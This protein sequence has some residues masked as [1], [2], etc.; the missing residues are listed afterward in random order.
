MTNGAAETVTLLGSGNSLGVYVPVVQLSRR[1]GRR[2]IPS[3]VNVLEDLYFD[4][5]KQKVAVY[6]KAFHDSFAVAR[7]GAQLARDISDCLDPSKVRLLLDTWKREKRTRFI[8]AT[9]FW[10]PVL[11][12]YE[13]EAGETRL[14]VDFLHL[15]ASLTP[16]YSVY[17]DRGGGFGHVWFYDPSGGGMSRRIAIT[18]EAPIPLGER[19][20][21]YLIHG[22]GWGIGTYRTAA[23]ELLEAGKRLDMLAY[24][25]EDIIPH[26]QIQYFRNDPDWSP[27][28]KNEEGRMQFPP[29][30]RLA[31]GHAPSYG[32]QEKYPPLFDVIR[33]SAAIISKPGGYSLMESLAAATPLVFL[34]PFGKHEASNADYW[35]KQGFGIRYEDWKDG[36]FAVD[37]LE[38]LHENLVRAN[39]YLIEYGGIGD[40]AKDD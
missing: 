7:K 39:H 9:G 15:D 17:G 21:R 26:E 25:D 37:M 20:E 18:E 12:Q 28:V 32:N 3:E 11:E 34:E 5:I 8:S 27:W 22:G 13:R 14:S 24:Y 10:L 29:L 40:A 1:L 2:G 16:S 33:R 30:A 38:D 6:K 19:E 4:P 23:R 35:I 31:D 36:G